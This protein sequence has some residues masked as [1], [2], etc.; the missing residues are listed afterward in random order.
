[1]LLM[2][3]T[4]LLAFTLLALTSQA[5]HRFSYLTT[6]NGLVEN[7]VNDIYQDQQGYM[8][9]ATQ[10]GISMY[11]GYQFTNYNV[12]N[13]SAYSLSD[14]FLWGLV[15]DSLGYIW[16]CS[17]NGINR[18]D[19][20]KGRVTWFFTA[21]NDNNQITSLAV[22]K[23]SIYAIIKE[24]VFTIPIVN[25]YPKQS[26]LIPS[27]QKLNIPIKPYSI[28]A[29]PFRK[30]GKDE[31]FFIGSNGVYNFGKQSILSANIE[32]KSSHFH[33]ETGICFGKIW[34]TNGKQLFYLDKANTKI[35]PFK[36]DFKDNF[37]FDFFAVGKELWV[38]TNNGIYVFVNDSLKYHITK[39]LD[40]NKSGETL[41]LP[42]QLATGGFYDKSGMVWVGTA[43]QGIATYKPQKDQFKYLGFETFGDKNSIRGM[44]QDGTNKLFVYGSKTY[45]L[46]LNSNTLC[47]QKFAQSA[48]KKVIPLEFKNIL[49]SEITT[50]GV[51]FNNDILVG[52][53]KK[54]LFLLDKNLN[55]KKSILENKLDDLIIYALLKRNN[56]EIWVATANGIY[57]LDKQYNTKKH[58]PVHKNGLNTAYFLT[59][60]E[61]SENTIWLGT[62]MGIFHYNEQQDFFKNY[63][64]LKSNLTKSPAFNFVSQFADF[65]DGNL[66]MSTYGGGLS[67]MNK[68]TELFTHFSL[69]R[70]LNNNV[71]NGMLSD[72]MGNLWLSTNKGISKFDPKMEKFTN[73]GKSDGL[74]F[75]DF[76]LGSTFKNNNGELFFG[77]PAGLIIFKPNE[78]K[79]SNYFPPLFID[80]VN[81]NYENASD[82]IDNNVIHL[83]PKDQ[84]LTLRF[85]GLNYSTSPNIK[86]RYTL[87]GYNK[88]WIITS[89]QIATYTSLPAGTYSFLVNVTNQSGVWNKKYS[90]LKIVV[91]PPFYKTWWFI[92]IVAVI[93][94]TLAVIFIRFLSQRKLKRHLQEMNILHEVNN[95]K[96]RISRDLHDNLGAELTYISSIIDQKAYLIND[97]EKKAD[98]ELISESS[99]HAM[100][101]MRETIWAI[102][103]EQITLE[104]F[105]EKVL[106]TSKKYAE[107]GN[108]QLKVNFG[109]ENYTLPPSKVIVL[110]RVC[111][112]SINNAVK[113]ALCNKIVVDIN[114]EENQFTITI[115]D[116]GN[117]FDI[118]KVKM[119]YGLLNMQERAVEIDSELKIFSEIGKGTS[120]VISGK[121]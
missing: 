38:N 77:T 96:Q 76:A 101:Q 113:Y 44:L 92:C 112:E 16:C 29:D 3:I 91:H 36:F 70:G 53:D 61:D 74:Y 99:R 55:I 114:A 17:R 65:G 94:S 39:S 107:V 25:H 34:F 59:I 67:K 98:L 111:Q 32:I 4:L 66:W 110:L 11:D 30:D 73:F 120:I 41:G 64:Y 45:V 105:A 54:G 28:F 18:I 1:M 37:I 88:N 86:Y 5:Q 84:A 75:T 19:K 63:P 71:C 13:N 83:Y 21:L 22:H 8:W 103:T 33:L 82:R 35:V 20:K 15:E 12:S 24:E 6:E 118:D 116:N 109:G 108:I 9:F 46:Q 87:K 42:S 117:G 106:T 10:D 97:P 31:L 81:I 93:L 43:E 57:I 52:T 27:S 47:S 100:R 115:K 14:N 85:V 48:V 104:N 40:P 72:P 68:Q 102:Q 26:N 79:T 23:G 121:V 90:T 2:R 7:S 62:N 80:D 119:G 60:F 49:A 50:I 56:G 58:W 89:N 69:E 78:I 51:G 95:E